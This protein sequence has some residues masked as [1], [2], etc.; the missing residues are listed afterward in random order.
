[1]DDEEAK[2][3][4]ERLHAF[5]QGSEE[6]KTDSP[7]YTYLPDI[8]PPKMSDDEFNKVID[9]AKT[10]EETILSLVSKAE[11]LKDN[12]KFKESISEW[13]KYKRYCRIMIMLFNN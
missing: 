1:M 2:Q 10:K 7:L 13:K 4:K 3:I 11:N 6:Q 12:N 5:V 9:S 8:I